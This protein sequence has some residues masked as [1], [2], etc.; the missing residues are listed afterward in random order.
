MN[1]PRAASGKNRFH[2]EPAT[3]I[4]DAQGRRLRTIDFHAHTMSP[5]VER[6]VADRPQKQAEPEIRLRT[7]G[8]VS[9]EYNDRV[10]LPQAAGPL[11]DLAVRLGDMDR[12]GVDLQ[13]V[14]PQPTQ[15]YYWADHDLALEIVAVQNEHIAAICAQYPERLVGLG[16]L[17]LQH[18]ELAVA[19][20]DHAVKNL[21]LRGIEISTSI[22]DRELSHAS[23]EPVWA[24][25]EELGCVVF[26]HPMGCS[27]GE[28]LQPA[29]LSN[30]V[31]QPVETTVALSHL[32]CGGVFDR[33]ADLKVCAAHG[34]GYLP[35]YIG[36]AD[37]AYHTR[38]DA[39][40]TVHAPSEYLRRI[41]F[42]SL[43]YSPAGLRKLI[44]QVGAEQVVVGTD[45]PFDMGHYDIHALVGT[46]AGLSA[47]QRAAI[48]GG[49]A[50]RLLAIAS[51][52]NRRATRQG[53]P[54]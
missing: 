47:E 13:V 11:S 2:T 5:A 29:Y 33:H 10:M 38:P 31:G 28:R 3:W 6:L 17:A 42:D 40:T 15:Y 39:R 51:P 32:I 27:L 25:A 50:A 19:Q 30:S 23:L 8:V 44:D 41:C 53:S 52:M 35:T 48:L 22:N 34:G 16:T 54:T 21:G 49:N 36:R 46:T 45:Y 24:K 4:R 37:H 7:M 26:I 12:M 1:A 9:V 20:L 43:V 18:P 14:S